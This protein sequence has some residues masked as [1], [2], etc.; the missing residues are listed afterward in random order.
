MT[1]WIDIGTLADIPQRGA[2]TVQID[3]QKEIAVFRTGDDHVFA[4]VDECPHKKGPLSQGIVHGHNVACPLHNWNIALRTGEA[5][6]N[7]EGCT[8][9]IAVRVEGERILIARPVAMP[10]A[11]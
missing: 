1:T 9:T 11:A 10:V 5:Q 7:D 3:G 8:P 4:L 6:G 2:R